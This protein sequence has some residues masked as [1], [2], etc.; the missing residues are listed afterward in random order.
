MKQLIGIISISFL[1]LISLYG[2]LRLYGIPV[3]S[4][5]LLNKLLITI[6]IVVVLSALLGTLIPFFFAGK[7][8]PQAV[9]LILFAVTM[10]DNKQVQQYRDNAPG[11]PGMAGA[12]FERRSR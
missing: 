4:P 6:G 12:A 2:I 8:D 5:E 9:C 1:L 10:Q 7:K 3:F 11:D